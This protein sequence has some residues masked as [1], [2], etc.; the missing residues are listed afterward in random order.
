MDSTKSFD[1]EPILTL[2]AVEV[3]F[4]KDIKLSLPELLLKSATILE[5]GLS[6]LSVLVG[7]VVPIPTLPVEW[8]N[9][10]TL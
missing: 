7:L 5:D 6:T 8:A 1:F 4:E 2:S 3:L 10:N 9:V